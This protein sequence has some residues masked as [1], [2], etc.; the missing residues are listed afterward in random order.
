MQNDIPI[1][2]VLLNAQYTP[3][4]PNVTASM[5]LGRVSHTIVTDVILEG[6]PT[7]AQSHAAQNRAPVRDARL[8]AND[9]PA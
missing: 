4:N 6:L 8:P 7:A 2:P 1:D 9:A 3:P 5:L